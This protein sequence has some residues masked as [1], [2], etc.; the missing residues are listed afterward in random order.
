MVARNSVSRAVVSA[1]VSYTHLYVFPFESCQRRNHERAET[2]IGRRTGQGK[3]LE[4][5]PRRLSARSCVLYSALT[6]TA[7][8]RKINP[9]PPKLGAPKGFSKT[10]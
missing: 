8:L 9:H 5:L 4:P 7:V 10:R 1:T 6:E 3:A 2:E